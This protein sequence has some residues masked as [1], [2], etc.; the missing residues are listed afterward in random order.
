MKNNIKGFTLFEVVIVAGIAVIVGTLIVGILIN[1]TGIINKESSIVTQGL[2]INDAIREVDT[3]GRQAV[4]VASGYPEVSPTY[5]TGANTL[6][7]KI[8]AIN[9][10][11]IIGDVYDFVVIT[12][13]SSNPKLLKEYIFPD[14]LSI[15]EDK[16]TILT[17]LLSSIEFEYL[18]NN[19]APIA[20]PSAIKIKTTISVLSKTSYS[21]QSRSATIVTSLR[22][23]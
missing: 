5:V 4:L 10:Q 22:N 2:N 13:D 16:N 19:D 17:N 21:D 7:L 12:K 20:A 6:V 18:D 1:N 3:Y 11:G 14:T 15:R 8:P 23:L 9:S